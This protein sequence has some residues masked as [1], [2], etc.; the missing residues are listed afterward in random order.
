MAVVNEQE[1]LVSVVIST[2]NRQAYLKEAISSVVGQTYRNIEVIIADDCSTESPKALVDAFQDSRLHLRINE[3]NIGMGPNLTS[4]FKLAKGKYVAS[5]NDDDVWQKDFLEKLVPLLEN[6]PEVVVAFCDYYVINSDSIVDEKLTEEHT[7]REKRAGLAAGIYQP[8]Y[9]L[10]LVDRAIFSSLAN[11]IRKDAVDWDKLANDSGASVFYDLYMTY[12]A[13]RSGKAAYYCPE[14]LAFYRVHEQSENVISGS[15]N[16]QAKIRKGKAGIFC[17]KTF[18]EDPVLQ[19]FK[20]HFERE[21]AHANTTLAIGLLRA[22]QVAE[23]RPYLLDAITA[24]KFNLR[25]LAALTLSYTPQ[26]IAR[27]FLGVAK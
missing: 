17:S 22:G 24:Q 19:E 7:K 11:V 10:A 16:V 12:L 1:P 3:A 8:Y 13:C 4:A 27:P 6:N 14:K 21:L 2:Y 26:T 5:I 20:P 9:K 18:S 25:T 23:A 15:K